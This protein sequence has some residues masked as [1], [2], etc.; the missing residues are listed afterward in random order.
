MNEKRDG[1]E[2]FNASVRDGI[3]KITKNKR[4]PINP[5]TFTK[6]RK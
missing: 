3:K 1:Q 5:K 4:L 6:L 2:I